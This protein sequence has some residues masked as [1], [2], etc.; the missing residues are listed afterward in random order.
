[1]A[2]SRMNEQVP[3]SPPT[4]SLN[5]SSIDGHTQNVIPSLVVTNRRNIESFSAEY[6]EKN[7]NLLHFG[8]LCCSRDMGACVSAGA[9][10]GELSSDKG[11]RPQPSVDMPNADNLDVQN[12]AL[13]IAADNRGCGRPSSQTS[14]Y[15]S[16]G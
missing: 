6:A 16:D 13:Q 11:A 14:S 2:S 4:L 8:G 9:I 5:D 3:G 15:R 7:R 10:M 12:K 1:M